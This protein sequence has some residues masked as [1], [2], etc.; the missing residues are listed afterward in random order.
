[1]RLMSPPPPP[2]SLLWL[3]Y[4]IFLPFFI[5][6][7]DSDS[8]QARWPSV[9]TQVAGWLRAGPSSRDRGHRED[10]DRDSRFEFAAPGPPPA[11]AVA[12]R[13]KVC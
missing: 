1:M 7:Y 2:T 8:V 9:V 5:L 3:A 12:V 4:I 10:R 6:I 13:N 11:A